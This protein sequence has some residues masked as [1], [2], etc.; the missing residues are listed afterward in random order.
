[1]TLDHFSNRYAQARERF[2]AQA[3][4]LGARLSEDVHPLPGVDGETLALDVAVLGDPAS[5][6]RLLVSSGCHGV[7][8]YCGSGIQLAAMSSP[9]RLAQAKQAGITLLFA[10]ALNPYGFSHLRRVTHEN[11]DLNRNFHDFS[12]PPTAG[13]DYAAIHDVLVPDAW[14]PTPENQGKLKA[15][16]ETHG[17]KGVQQIV[18]AGQYVVPQGLFYG[19]REPTW[20]HLAVRR[21]LR[22]HASGASHLGWIDLHTGLGPSGHGERIG[23]HGL[24]ASPEEDHAAFARASRWWDSGGQTPLTRVQDG[25]SSSASLNG[26]MGATGPQE[27]PGTVITRLTLEYGTQPPLQVLQ[28]LRAEQWATNHPKAPVESRQAAK[29]MLFEAFFT[30]TPEWKQSVLDQGLQAIDQALVGLADH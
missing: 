12:T 8:G 22:Q 21:M 26:T 9:T 1:M 23:P 10:H 11:V 5:P 17:M 24:G 4:S 19:G 29:R 28:A 27:C 16:L 14:P 7:E 25:S 18:S 15:I 20:S 6:K 13:A 3:R 2:L 30:D